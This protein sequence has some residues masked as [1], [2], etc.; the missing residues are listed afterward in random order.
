MIARFLAA[1][2]AL[3]VRTRKGPYRADLTA[4]DAHAFRTELAA[5]GGGAV[6]CIPPAEPVPGLLG[7]WLR[8][9]IFVGVSPQSVIRSKAD[10][11]VQV[12]I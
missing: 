1:L 10:T 4:E 12:V 8:C 7:T 11:S 3:K 9:D 2:G 6:Q 5:G